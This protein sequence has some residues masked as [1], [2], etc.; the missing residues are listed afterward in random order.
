MSAAGSQLDNFYRRLLLTGFFTH[1]WGKPEHM[2]KIFALRRSLAQRSAAVGYVDRAHPVTVEKDEER[3]DHRRLT[4]SFETPC[5]RYLDGDLLPEE[6]RR[7]HFEVV[8]PKG[9]MK[10]GSPVV[11]HFAGTGDH[12]FWRRRKFAAMPLLEERNITSVIIE[13]PFYGLRK[14]E[15][16]LRC[17]NVN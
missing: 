8:M 15:Q 10:E 1:G 7:A 14:P 3:K 12:F 17:E 5:A 16:Q 9:P 11:W 2:K 6:C 4:C 13:N